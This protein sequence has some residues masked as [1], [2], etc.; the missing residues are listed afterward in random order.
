MYAAKKWG[1]HIALE[2]G[3]ILF[4]SEPERQREPERHTGWSR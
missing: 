3:R 2:K 1:K 4:Q